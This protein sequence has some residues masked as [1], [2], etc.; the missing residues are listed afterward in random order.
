MRSYLRIFRTAS[1]DTDEFYR[2]LETMHEHS[3]MHFLVS[4]GIVLDLPSALGD[5]GEMRVGMKRILTSYQL[6]RTLLESDSNPH[7]IAIVSGVIS[8]WEMESIQSIYEIMKVKSY[9]HRCPIAMNIVGEGGVY[10]YYMGKRVVSSAKQ[11]N[12][13][14]G[15]YQWEEQRQQ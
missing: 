1:L 2:F 10:E 9:Y 11:E 5:T 7:F 13:E 8:S 12:M 4:D 6:Q 14:G 3:R 15:L